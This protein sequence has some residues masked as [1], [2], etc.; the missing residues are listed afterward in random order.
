MPYKYRTRPKRCSL[1]TIQEEPAPGPVISRSSPGRMITNTSHHYLMPAP[2]T[3]P[4]RNS[5]SEATPVTSTWGT[6]SPRSLI[7]DECAILDDSD[8]EF[9][10]PN[11]LEPLT[12]QRSPPKLGH[13]LSLLG[14][15]LANV[16]E[17]AKRPRHPSTPVEGAFND[18]DQESDDYLEMRSRGR[19]VRQRRNE[20]LRSSP[21]RNTV[22]SPPP[23]EMDRGNV[24]A[25]EDNVEANEGSVEANEDMVVDGDDDEVNDYIRAVNRANANAGETNVNAGDDK[26]FWDDFME[27]HGGYNSHG[28]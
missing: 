28:W 23:E 19:R 4:R 22:N 5:S 18:S 21:L 11:S 17:L 7:D 1:P 9:G 13:S 14:L 25:G 12:F 16:K 15:M 10:P 20:P 8:E 6:I 2:I 24:E 26:T 3:I 27:N